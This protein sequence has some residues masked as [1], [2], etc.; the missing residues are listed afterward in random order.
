MPKALNGDTKLCRHFEEQWEL[1]NIERI[2]QNKGNYEGRFNGSCSILIKWGIFQNS[3]WSWSLENWNLEPKELKTYDVKVVLNG[4]P[5]EEV[6]ITLGNAFNA[7]QVTFNHRTY[8]SPLGFWSGIGG[9]FLN[10]DN[11]K[12]CKNLNHVH[13]L[14]QLYQKN[15]L[16]LQN[17]ITC[18]IWTS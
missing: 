12:N 4:A 16:K 7:Q 9:E 3:V 5:C 18:F 1:S 2:F 17:E 8:K 6:L 15:V 14:L 11:I 13:N 10:F